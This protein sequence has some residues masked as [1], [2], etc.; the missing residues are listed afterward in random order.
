MLLEGKAFISAPV[1]TKGSEEIKIR[2]MKMKKLLCI[3]AVAVLGVA[4]SSRVTVAEK[5]PVRSMEKSYSAKIIDSR[6]IQVMH[7]ENLGNWSVYV[8]ESSN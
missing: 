7:K 5:K 3:M 8:T 4:L 1:K 6:D 2:V